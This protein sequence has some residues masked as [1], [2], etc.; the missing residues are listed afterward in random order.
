MG[1][2]SIKKIV[3][4]QSNGV[5]SDQWPTRIVQQPTYS[6][7]YNP[8]PCNNLVESSF[9]TATTST[10]SHQPPSGSSLSATSSAD[11]RKKK[12]PLRSRTNTMMSSSSCSCSSC[13]S[14]P[15]DNASLMRPPKENSK[16]CP[17]PPPSAD[18]LW[19]GVG[20]QNNLVSDSR[21]HWIQPTTPADTQ[22][23]Q[24]WH[25]NVV[26]KQERKGQEDSSG[27]FSSLWK[28][29]SRNQNDK[30]PTGNQGSSWMTLRVPS[31][32]DNNS[33][34]H[35][36]MRL[37]QQPLM[38][39]SMQASLGPMMTM[40]SKTLG[41]QYQANGHI[42][43]PNPDDILPKEAWTDFSGNDE[44]PRFSGIQASSSEAADERREASS[45]NNNRLYANCSDEL[46]N[47]QREANNRLG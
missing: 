47:H 16:Y 10:G 9:S 32:Q 19:Q 13:S 22:S 33:S 11:Q 30:P 31:V 35:C 26:V 21:G 24:T 2:N 23:R 4:Q 27:L 43:M 39:P 25:K 45:C 40:Q 5:D 41:R 18:L 7:V 17:P 29:K 37:H 6:A 8:N 42:V 1:C 36:M 3:T 14:C 20:M 46:Q 15:E 38:P 28:K 12:C 34:M 44:W